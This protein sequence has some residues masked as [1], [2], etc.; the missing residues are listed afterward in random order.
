MRERPDGYF[1]VSHDEKITVKVVKKN[2]VYAAAFSDL[3]HSSWD[4]VVQPDALT[5]IR[6]F[7]SPRPVDSMCTFG[8]LFDFI[9][10][11]PAGDNYQVL[12]SGKNGTSALPRTIYPPPV[13]HRTYTF[14]VEP[15]TI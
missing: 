4:S 6:T 13:A 9:G 15:D 11:V 7:T 12:I 14:V 2:P 8:I 1:G 3:V 10:D 5:E